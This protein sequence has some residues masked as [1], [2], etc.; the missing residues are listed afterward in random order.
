MAKPSARAAH[1]L[2]SMSHNI[3]ARKVAASAEAIERHARETERAARQTSCEGSHAC[4]MPR[5]GE[6]R[7]E[8]EAREGWPRGERPK[9]RR[10]A[11][12]S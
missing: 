3:G 5:S 11:H 2:K 4:S 1:A 7:L 9:L 6:C 12:R 8:A 10:A